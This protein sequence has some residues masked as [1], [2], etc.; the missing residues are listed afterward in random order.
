MCRE[1]LRVIG[2]VQE[3]LMQAL[4]KHR[5]KLLRCAIPGKIGAADV[6]DKQ[7]VAGKHGS[8]PGRLGEVCDRDTHALD[9]VTGSLHEIESALPELNGVAVFHR[10]VRERCARGFSEVDARSSALR[11]LMMTGNEVGVQVRFDN[12]LD[13]Q[14]LFLGGVYVNVHV[15]LRVDDG[16]NSLRTDQVGSVC[17]TSEQELFHS[18]WF[19]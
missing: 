4:V 2:K 13:L 8:R 16:R 9:R 12:V 11:K 17:Q 6:S 3:L 15:A 14:A 5:G 10:R 18:N 7:R 1:N 19:H